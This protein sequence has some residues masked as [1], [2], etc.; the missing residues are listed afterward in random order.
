MFEPTKK[1]WILHLCRHTFADMITTSWT[2]KRL[3]QYCLCFKYLAISHFIGS[4]G[5]VCFASIGSPVWIHVFSIRSNSKH[6]HL[7]LHWSTAGVCQLPAP[8]T[9]QMSSFRTK[10]LCLCLWVFMWKMCIVF[11]FEITVGGTH[12]LCHE[13]FVQSTQKYFWWKN[14]HIRL[15]YGINNHFVEIPSCRDDSSCFWIMSGD[16]NI[17][18]RTYTTNEWI[19]CWKTNLDMQS[20]QW[21]GMTVPCELFPLESA[22]FVLCQWQITPLVSVEE[23]DTSALD[24][25]RSSNRTSVPR[26]IDELGDRWISWSIENAGVDHQPKQ[27]YFASRW[28]FFCG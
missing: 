20:V 6:T 12:R 14:C 1:E 28:F 15:W 3:L 26:R 24:R 4:H 25:K 9:Y 8:P 7:F 13:C 22:R 18:F 11:F 2:F 5:L 10:H 27:L 16:V 23:S 19:N 21:H 17:D